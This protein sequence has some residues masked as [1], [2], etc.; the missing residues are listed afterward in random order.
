MIDPNLITTIRVGELPPVVP[1]LTSKIPHEVGVDL[2]YMTVQDLVTFLQPFIGTFQYEKK[3]L[4]VDAQYIIDNFDST[5]LGKNICVG[6]AIMN[7]QN[8]T[9]NI[10]GLVSIAYGAVNNVL[11]QT[12]GSRDAVVV[13]HTHTVNQIKSYNNTFGLNG[14]YDRS[15]TASSAGIATESTGVSGLNKNMQPYIVELHIIKL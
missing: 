13:A 9:T 2:K 12:G 5:G 11:K 1:S 8:G 14:F 4:H 10:D 3:V 7:G 6:W 15:N